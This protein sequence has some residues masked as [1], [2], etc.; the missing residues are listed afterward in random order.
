MR[1]KNICALSALLMC[2][3]LDA[4]ELAVEGS[5]FGELMHS[6]IL[7]GYAESTGGN[8]FG[9]SFLISSSV[10][11][12]IV[13]QS[14]DDQS[15]FVLNTGLIKPNRDLIFINGLDLIFL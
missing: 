2:A 4:D 5:P 7:R 1:L 11:E 6:H 15:T 12:T 14:S 8:F 3:C 13:G 9:A 10:S